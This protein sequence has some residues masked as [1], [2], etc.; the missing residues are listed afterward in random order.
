MSG[1]IT[2]IIEDGVITFSN[3]SKSAV[4]TRFIYMNGF[5]LFDLT[6]YAEHSIFTESKCKN[7]QPLARIHLTIEPNS[8]YIEGFYVYPQT[9][10][11]EM[12]PSQRN[13]FKNLGELVFSIGFSHIKKYYTNYYKL[14]P[15]K[16]NDISVSAQVFGNKYDHLNAYDH[17]NLCI[18]LDKVYRLK[19]NFKNVQFNTNP[20]TKLDQSQIEICKKDK[21]HYISIKSDLVDILSNLIKFDPVFDMYNFKSE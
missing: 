2:Q 4:K 17:S 8:V 11:C 7:T 10:F 13:A 1:D 3:E 21:P 5:E 9:R 16:I 14:E 6:T 20:Y 19:Y 15:N 12:T 18:L